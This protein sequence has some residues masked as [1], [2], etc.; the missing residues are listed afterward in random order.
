ML[1]ITLIVRT[2][3]IHG[4]LTIDKLY[5]R[6]TLLSKN[7]NGFTYACHA[8]RLISGNKQNRKPIKRTYKKR[9]VDLLADS[10]V[11]DRLVQQGFAREDITADL[12]AVKT[13]LIL[14]IRR[15]R[16]GNLNGEKAP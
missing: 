9:D 14:L 15:I 12:V 5:K 10:Y 3:K 4:E 1:W 11:R 13:A 2:C 8:C 6:K 16:E 7:K